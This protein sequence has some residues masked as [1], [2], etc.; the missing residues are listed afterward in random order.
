MKLAMRVPRHTYSRTWPYQ[1]SHGPIGS[2][3]VDQLFESIGVEHKTTIEASS[4]G[5]DLVR[6][7]PGIVITDLF[8]AFQRT[9]ALS[10]YAT[11]SQDS[12]TNL[13]SCFRQT[14]NLRDCL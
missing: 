5:V 8:T 10:L 4:E 2:M 13:A 12:N 3:R 1:S 11:F 14:D 6:A 7:G 9:Q